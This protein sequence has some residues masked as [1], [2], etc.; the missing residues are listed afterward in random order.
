MDTSKHSSLSTL[1]EQL[2]LSA[3]R[4]SVEQFIARHAPLEQGVALADAPF[5]NQGQSHFIR[6]SLADDSDWAEIIDELDAL[7]RH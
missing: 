5:W 7:L 3:D 6:E 2:G 4:P 1:F